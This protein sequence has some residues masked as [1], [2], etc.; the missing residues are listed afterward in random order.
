MAKKLIQAW[1]R[2]D[3]GWQSR[4][5]T[6]RSVSSRSS[7]VGGSYIPDAST[8]G[9]TVSSWTNQE[10]NSAG[11]ISLTTA[12]L[13]CTNTTHWGEVRHQAPGISHN[14][15]RFAGP[16]LNL[17]YAG[18]YGSS[19]AGTLVKSYGSGYYHWIAEN[20]LFDP[21]LW[22]DERG[23]T[24]MTDATFIAIDAIDGGDCELRWCQIRNIVDGLHFF[25]AENISD[26]GNT[27]WSTGI[28]ASAS[29]RFAVVDRCFIEK[30]VY[31][32]GDT[33]RARPGAQ[34]DGRPHCDGAQIMQGANLWITG[35]MI[36][37]VRDSVGYTTWPNTGNPGNTG[38]D[39]ANACLMIKQEG[40]YS[41]GDVHWLTNILIENN[42]LE[43]GSATVNSAVN[44]GNDLSGVTVRNNKFF[45]RQYGWGLN[46]D[47]NG[48]PTSSHSGY[49][50][51]VAMS[52]TPVP[53]WSGNTV[54]ETGVTIPF[55]MG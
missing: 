2:T 45:A 42:F 20:C 10:A 54:Y 15:C 19:G 3:S 22:I 32:A 39:Y 34:S 40:T 4:G 28:T 41:S 51:Q 7:L 47:T 36:G 8:T 48:T 31:V 13:V 26:S 50:W 5:R 14:N 33:Y 49:G 37:G 6:T 35:S 27:G 9:P 16:D 11:V 43:G 52:G 44:S 24:A 18:T 55:V 23:R 21:N 12:N 30:S 29:T 38:N 25:H 46:V 53:S 1:H 17:V